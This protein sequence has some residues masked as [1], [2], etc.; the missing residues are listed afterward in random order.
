MRDEITFVR[1]TQV[2]PTEIAAH[3]PLLTGA[4]DMQTVAFRGSQ[5][6]LLV[7]RWRGALGEFSG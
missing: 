6:G 5:G 1:L 7:E 2:A 3:V 4:W